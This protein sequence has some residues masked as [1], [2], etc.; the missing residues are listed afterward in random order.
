MS[1]AR[2]LYRCHG[3]RLVSETVNTEWKAEAITEETWVWE[4]DYSKPK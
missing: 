2:E 4:A 3:F 1:A